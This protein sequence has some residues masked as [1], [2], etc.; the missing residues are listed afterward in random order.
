MPTENRKRYAFAYNKMQH[1]QPITAVF[2]TT[3]STEFN[4]S[5]TFKFLPDAVAN[6]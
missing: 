2:H 5:L 1:P 4:D 6:I 3:L